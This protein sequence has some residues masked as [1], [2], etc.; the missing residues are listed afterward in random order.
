MLKLTSGHTMQRQLHAFD[1]FIGH[2]FPLT[3]FKAF[4]WQQVTT[5]SFMAK[6]ITV[7]A[8]QYKYY[9]VSSALR[10]V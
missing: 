7:E 8:Q 3:L 1:S 10:D 9:L 6:T 5:A 4:S 2:P